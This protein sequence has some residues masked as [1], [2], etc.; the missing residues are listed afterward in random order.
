MKYKIPVVA[1]RNEIIELRKSGKTVSEIAKKY[2]VT[3]EHIRQILLPQK[4][5]VPTFLKKLACFNKYLA[6]FETMSSSRWNRAVIRLRGTERTLEIAEERKAFV[7]DLWK[8][9]NRSYKDI[10]KMLNRKPGSIQLI[11]RKINHGRENR[12]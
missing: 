12:G 1:K 4:E 10:G 11:I 3:S 8:N 5:R 7:Y 6:D 9:D 2:K